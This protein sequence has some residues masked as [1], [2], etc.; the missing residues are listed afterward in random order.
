MRVDIEVGLH[1]IYA[2]EH[3]MLADDDS[4]RSYAM[5]MRGWLDG[6]DTV[7]IPGGE[8]Y[9]QLMQRYRP[10][11]ENLAQAHLSGGAARDVLVVSHGAAIRTMA[12]HAAGVDPDFAFAGYLGNCRFIV[13][14]PQG[15][16]FGQWK[17]ARWAD[18][19]HQI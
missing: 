1:E 3:E 12:T 18:V 6:D 2:G 19:D 15:R 14:E 16:P 5:A 4:H 7:R 17:L 11:L 13:L 10:V 9:S 8:T